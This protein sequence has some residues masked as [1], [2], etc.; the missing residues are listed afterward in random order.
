MLDQIVRRGQAGYVDDDDD[1]QIL[2]V[3]RLSLKQER[4][5][6]DEQRLRWEEDRHLE[7]L[8]VL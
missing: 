3:M 7:R 1:A 2:V 4:Q 6:A 5:R 8:P